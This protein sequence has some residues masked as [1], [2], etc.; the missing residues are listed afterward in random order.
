MPSLNLRAFEFPPNLEPDLVR[1]Y[2]QQPDFALQDLRAH[3]GELSR[4]VGIYFLFYTGESELYRDIVDMN[5]DGL[6]KPIYVGKAVAAGSRSGNSAKVTAGLYHRL[7]IHYTSIDE[8]AGLEVADFRVRVIAMEGAAAVQWAEQTFITRLQPAWNVAIAGFGIKIPGAGRNEQKISVW[9]TL[10][11]GRSL[12][13]D[14]TRQRDL[15]RE[16]ESALRK[17]QGKL[18][19]DLSFETADSPV[20]ADAPNATPAPATLTE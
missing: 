3:A 2:L 14:L 15:E 6:I 20:P 12:A 17:M 8:A 18:D 16:T 19:V 10:H 5:A 1:F 13:K 9:D 11:P 7:N 4:Y